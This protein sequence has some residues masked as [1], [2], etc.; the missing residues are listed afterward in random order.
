ML[1]MY[2]DKE[3]QCPAVN[4]NGEV[5]YFNHENEEHNLKNARACY[6][7]L[8]ILDIDESMHEYQD[9]EADY[10]EK[11]AEMYDYM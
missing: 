10:F 1:K 9:F 5:E 7:N 11:Q 6:N 4:F 8:K 3:K 2:Y